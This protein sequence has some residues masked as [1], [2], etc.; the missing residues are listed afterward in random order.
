MCGITKK[1]D[2]TTFLINEKGI[3]TPF[4]K[5]FF[6]TRYKQAYINEM[7]EFINCLMNNN[8]PSVGIKNAI[9]SIRIALAAK[10]SYIENR[11][12]ELREIS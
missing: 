3:K 11:K 12:V 9:M 8:I 7:K 2:K 10:L 5:D 6:I 1:N 4:P